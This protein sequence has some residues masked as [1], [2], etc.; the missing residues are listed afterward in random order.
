MAAKQ[1]NELLE[2]GCMRELSRAVRVGGEVGAQVTCEAR[3]QACYRLG[4]RFCGLPLLFG[5]VSI[6]F[7]KHLGGV[8]GV[9]TLAS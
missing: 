7:H 3:I 1:S 5:L 9:T 4:Q 6:R 8:G 2:G